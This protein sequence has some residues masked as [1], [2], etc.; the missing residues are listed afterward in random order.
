MGTRRTRPALVAALVG[1]T[2]LTGGCSSGT[3]AGSSP[4]KFDQTWTKKI[5]D[6]TC[7]DWIGSMN[8]RER[9]VASADLLISSQQTDGGKQALP[10][11]S[12]INAFAAD[13]STACEAD[14]NQDISGI[15]AT[16]YVVGRTKYG[17]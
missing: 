10:A 11:D 4:G 13:I 2:L 14:V 12:L 15:A 1:L 16:V 17:P 5:G 9:F 8:E 6:T 7:G 3:G